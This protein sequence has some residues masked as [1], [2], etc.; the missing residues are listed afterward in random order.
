MIRL[1]DVRVRR[2]I[3][4]LITMSTLSRRG[5]LRGASFKSPPKTDQ[6][7]WSN[8]APFRR[9]AK[10]PKPTHRLMIESER[11]WLLQIREDLVEIDKWADE[12]IPGAAAWR[13]KIRAKLLKL[14]GE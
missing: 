14:V 2:S 8:V 6:S 3:I 4:P 1:G 13:D 10:P 7:A 12:G 5:L 11:K 9:V